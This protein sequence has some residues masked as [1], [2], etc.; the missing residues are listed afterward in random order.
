MNSGMLNPYQTF[1]M[2]QGWICPRCNTVNA[3]TTPYCYRC[4]PPGAQV[5]KDTTGVNP[6]EHKPITTRAGDY[7][8][9]DHP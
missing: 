1:G 7:D 9:K 8:N 6:M 5:A 3:P 2:Q 4:A